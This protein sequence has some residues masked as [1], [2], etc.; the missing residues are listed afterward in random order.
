MTGVQ[1][2]AL[3]IYYVQARFEFQLNSCVMTLVD[4]QYN[5]NIIRAEGTDLQIIVGVRNN[6]SIVSQV[7]LGGLVI[8]DHYT[9]D[10]YYPHILSKYPTRASREQSNEKKNLV[11]ISIETNPVSRDTD[12]ALDIVLGRMNVIVNVPLFQ[13]L[14]SFFCVPT[15][16]DLSFFEEKAS[17]TF[18][19]F[20]QQLR[21]QLSSALQLARRL[22]AQ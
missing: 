8:K 14:I 11:S 7:T 16:V 4:S 1:T 15:T 5:K 2:C 12:L 17:K 21:A 19:T 22:V 6:S 3:P 18:D 10:T 9:S 13:R 20:R